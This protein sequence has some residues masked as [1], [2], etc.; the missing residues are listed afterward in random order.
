MLYKKK[1]IPIHHSRVT[2]LSVEF[3]SRGGEWCRAWHYIKGSSSSS[4]WASDKSSGKE[5]QRSTQWA[6]SSN[7]GSSKFMDADWGWW[8]TFPTMEYHYSSRG[9][10]IA[11]LDER[12][13]DLVLSFFRSEFLYLSLMNSLLACMPIM[14]SFHIFWF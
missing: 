14:V 11:W 5:I 13:R 12:G 7:L 10:I 6:D 9:L 2:N 3:V 8:T 4:S 1:F